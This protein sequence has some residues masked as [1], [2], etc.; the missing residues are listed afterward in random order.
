MMI[1]EDRGISTRCGRDHN[2]AA[3]LVHL[4][5]AAVSERRPHL[6]MTALCRYLPRA[7]GMTTSKMSCSVSTA[8]AARR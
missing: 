4:V 1:H 6:W 7:S 5:R 2:R 8:Q 3:P